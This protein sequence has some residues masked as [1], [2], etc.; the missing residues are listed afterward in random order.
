MI[1]RIIGI[2]VGALVVAVLLL[3]LYEAAAAISYLLAGLSVIVP[4]LFLA[5]NFYFVRYS[6]LFFWVGVIFSKLL[7]IVLIVLSIKLLKDP[8]YGIFLLGIIITT[9]LPLGYVLISK[10]LR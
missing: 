3:W 5:A 2:Q 10:R 1:P 7:T 9:H 4:S 8:R 6:P